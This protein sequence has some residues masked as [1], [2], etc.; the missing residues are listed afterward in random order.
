MWRIWVKYFDEQGKLTGIGYYWQHYE[1]RKNAERVAKSRYGGSKMFAY[2]V[3]Q[4][5]PW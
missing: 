4:T 3:A 5:C 2:A 1:R